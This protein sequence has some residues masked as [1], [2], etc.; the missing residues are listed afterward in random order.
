M[1]ARV[2]WI[3]LAAAV[4]AASGKSAAAPAGPADRFLVR[5][6]QTFHLTPRE[7]VVAVLANDGTALATEGA[8]ADLPRLAR[9]GAR[10]VAVRDATDRAAL[11]NMAEIRAVLPVFTETRS[12]TPVVAL[13][14]VAAR[15]APGVSADC[16]AR[17]AAAHGLEL[18]ADVPTQPE[19]VHLRLRDPAAHD[20]FDATAALAG[21]GLVRWAEPTLW[22]QAQRCATP[23]DTYFPLQWHLDTPGLGV[24]DADLDALQAWDTTVGA[25]TTVYAVLDDGV[26]LAHP[27]LRIW[28]NLG[29]ASDPPGDHDGNGYAN[30]VRGWDFADG[31]ADPSP[32]AFI[33]PHNVIAHNDIH[34]T[35]VAG[36]TAALGSNERGVSGV[37]MDGQVMPVRLLAA[38]QFVSEADH[39]AAIRYAADNGADVITLAYTV[40][41]PSL[42]VEDALRHALTAGRGG[43]GC[44]VFAAAG[45]LALS[46]VRWP[47]ASPWTMAVGAVTDQDLAA[48]G[49]NFGSRLDLCGPSSGGAAGLV[50]TDVTLENRGFD[51]L[52]PGGAYT[53]S[54]GGT[55]AATA[56]ASGV[57][58][59]VL[60]ANPD[61]RWHEVWAV[62][63][64]SA[65]RAPPGSALDYE[66]SGWGNRYGWGRLNAARAVARALDPTP[67]DDGF[68]PN[69][70]FTQFPSVS[71]PFFQHLV[72]R[73]DDIFA[74]LA[75]ANQVITVELW[76]LP[77][78]PAPELQLTTVSGFVI[79]R[80]EPRAD[81]LEL[82]VQNGFIDQGLAVRVIPP[83]GVA[84]MGYTLS[85]RNRQPDAWEG[86]D[87]F[88]DA[89]H[90]VSSALGA[91]LALS[92]F[93]D[94]PGDLDIFAISGAAG[95][96]VA[97]ETTARRLVPP[98]PL[99]T[100]LTLL[101]SDGQTVVAQSDDAFDFDSRIEATLPA[102]DLYFVV[103]QDAAG[104]GGPDFAYTLS[105][106]GFTPTFPTTTQIADVLLGLLPEPPQADVTRDG[107]V[108]AAD[109]VWLV[110][111]DPRP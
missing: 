78:D 80:A 33:F 58:G 5:A 6:G 82:L 93:I 92:G 9:P 8:P 106:Q 30:D 47:A 3:L 107:T 42:E 17:W 76:H 40:P 22:V 71:T 70:T 64:T 86:N 101:R 87:T 27:D 55:S 75:R 56:L 35:P 32:S 83:P 24:P 50:T 25:P 109:L 14:Q 67:V 4:T 79:A 62:L 15:L 61:L 43:R 65:D 12:R 18:A 77:T 108:D 11:S 110:N 36:L 95:D 74:F 59:L 103:V 60:A 38:G 49:A 85:I 111:S 105:A 99:D 23:D 66:P 53:R 20:V 26:D 34:G 69:D 44:A 97:I 37:V 94:P 88:A 28:E 51:D 16:L 100:L 54:F 90:V 1:P 45:D 73:D 7:D 10:L 63:A 48:T 68:E 52:D 39:A 31:D 72:A 84:S 89:P 46:E 41:L 104:G 98:S 91:P 19:I 13:D 29:E 96:T 2:I 57:A 21:S 81:G 102:D